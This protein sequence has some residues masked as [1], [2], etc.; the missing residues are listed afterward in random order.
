MKM[1]LFLPFPIG[2][3]ADTLA[4]L[5]L[6]KSRGA[7]PGICNVVGSSISRLT[8]AGSYTHAGLKL[9]L[10]LQKHLLCQV[11]VLTIM[12]FFG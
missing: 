9:V 4:A 11:T 10:L 3:T 1:I 12:D 7:T 6:A 5:E 2:E 8:D